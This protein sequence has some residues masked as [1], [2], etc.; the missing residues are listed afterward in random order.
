MVSRNL[1]RHI[2]IASQLVRV[3]IQAQAQYRVDFLLQMVMAAFWVGWNV[4]PMWLVFDLKPS[5]AGWSRAEAMLVM[6]AFL[7][8]KSLLEGVVSPNL[9]ALVAHIRQG[10]F[11]FI[12]L[13]PID[14]QLLVSMSKVMPAKLVDFSC[15][16]VMAIWSVSVIDPTPTGAQIL[17]GAA[18]L[19][20]S[21]VTLYALWLLVICSVFWFVRIDNLSY[22]FS[23]IFDAGRWPVA[24]FRGWMRVVLTFVLPVVMMTSY[25][26]LALLGRLDLAS[27]LAACTIALA[28]FFIA[29]SVWGWAI[30]HYASASS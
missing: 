29:R 12:L 15:G 27:A 24:L 26:A 3:S 2:A 4:A 21:A 8:L 5:I 16:V 17:V 9:L 30:Q 11:D 6:S 10:T 1:M 14:S 25:P 28:L 22:L 7:I 20:T 13:K 23:S 19:L 18:M